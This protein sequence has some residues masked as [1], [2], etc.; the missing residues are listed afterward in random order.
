MPRLPLS[1][2][3]APAEQHFQA[4]C[5]RRQG[6]AQVGDGTRFPYML[7]G[8]ESWLCLGGTGT[9][10][11]QGCSGL[12]GKEVGQAHANPFDGW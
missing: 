9:V 1:R 4:L 6:W 7:R 8:R 12:T 11:A 5:K 3:P 10:T 2:L